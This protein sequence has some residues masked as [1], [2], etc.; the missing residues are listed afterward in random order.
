MAASQNDVPP[1]PVDAGPAGFGP[2]FAALMIDWA[3]CLLAS[4]LYADPFTVAWPAV[5]LLIA[6][7]AVCI[8]FFGRTL[9]MTLARLRCVSYV[10]GAAIGLLRAT[11]RAALLA[12]LVPALILDGQGRGLHDRAAGSI[13]LALPKP[14]RG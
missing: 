14:P 2:R 7:N 11:V 5:A 12:L 6:L 1:T 3:F 4:S 9:G 13:V 10:D 8:G